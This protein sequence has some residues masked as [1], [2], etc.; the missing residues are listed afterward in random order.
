MASGSRAGRIF[1]S[2]ATGFLVVDVLTKWWAVASLAPVHTRHPVIGDWVTFTL[3]YNPGAA[4]GLHLGNWSRWIFIALTL[5]AVVILTR[6]YRATAQDDTIKLT[7]LGMILGGALGNLVDRVRSAQGV[8][9]FID[10]GIGDTRWPTFN[11]ADIGVSCG[12]L[13]LAWVLW[14]ED[15]ALAASPAAATPAADQP[16][17]AT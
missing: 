10:I 2:V 9:D 11:V 13:I 12:A 6:M 15:R 17:S 1:W 14:R 3:L 8:V 5:G 16:S 7:S 4:F